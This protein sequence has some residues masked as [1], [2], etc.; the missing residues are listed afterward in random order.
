MFGLDASEQDLLAPRKKRPAD[1]PDADGDS[2]VDAAN[3]MTKSSESKSPASA[4]SSIDSKPASSDLD[5]AVD[6][7]VD[8]PLPVDEVLS[9][10]AIGK[11]V[12]ASEPAAD[13]GPTGDVP[14][15][16]RRRRS[17]ATKQK[18]KRSRREPAEPKV[19]EV[20]RPEFKP[21]SLFMAT[22]GML[23]DVRVLA[24]SAV[25]VLIMLIGGFSSE[26]IF[27]VG[28]DTEV[29]TITESMYKYFTSFL[30]GGVPYLIGVLV[31]WTVAGFVFRDAVQGHAKFQ[32]WTAG[33]QASF[34]PTFLL[35]GFSFFIAGLPGSIVFVLIIPLRMM[36]APL[37]L[38]SAWYNGS[39]WQIVS[40]DWYHVV[41]KNKSQ[42]ITFYGCFVALAFAGLMTGLVFLARS[43]SDLMAV[44]LVLTAIG[45]CMNTLITLVFAALAGWHVGAVIECLE[46]ND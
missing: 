37:F 41:N 8:E 12:P 14:A 46:Q 19:T 3:R 35:F 39:P 20:H 6:L 32:G 23:S 38:I 10:D 21:A 1:D 26:A 9:L 40:S 5:L 42:W 16:D 2:A 13:D 27:P 22:V 36:V 31:L 44:D 24:V 25:A 43:F 29:L 28:S 34:W 15:A 18:N 33:G 4:R 45:I 30:F 11:L 17:N 7:D